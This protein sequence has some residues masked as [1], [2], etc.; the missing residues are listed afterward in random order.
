MQELTHKETNMAN[1]IPFKAP[2]TYTHIMVDTETLGLAPNS[3]ILSIGAVVFCPLRG[4]GD[5]YYAEIDPD[6]YFGDIDFGTIKFWMEQS[7]KGIPCPINGT[8]TAETVLREF[9]LWLWTISHGTELVVWANG[10]DFDIPKLQHA[11][12]AHLKSVPK[13]TYSS[14]RDA[15]TLYKTFGP[16][17]L[18]PPQVNKHNALD[19]AKWQATYLCSI[20]NALAEKDVYSE[21]FQYE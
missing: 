21:E 2:K 19:D 16:Y 12:S 4:L 1:T 8:R 13:W 6:T 9:D 7:A 11:Y 3:V 20:L 18:K 15:R 10:T 14:V 17:G 5:D